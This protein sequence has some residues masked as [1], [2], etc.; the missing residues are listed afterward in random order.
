MF[1]WFRKSTQR[2]KDDIDANKTVEFFH[3]LSA[4]M[5]ELNHPKVKAFTRKIASDLALDPAFVEF[6][7][8]EKRPD[9]F[10][11]WV[12]DVGSGWTCYVPDEFD[13]AYP[14]WSTNA[15][16]TL[17]LVKGATLS[18]GKGWHDNPD[19]EMIAET[20]QGL[21]TNLIAEI[22]GVGVQDEELKR[23]AEFCGY[24]FLDEFLTRADETPD[25]SWTESLARFIA[26]VD[27]RSR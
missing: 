5:D 13:V 4:A 21:L 25:A 27:A 11:H 10:E 8:S 12:E 17:I 2:P 9:C 19:M 24:R 15:D 20:T 18:F 7:F 22:A 14:L 23:A 3:R 26:D 6:V 16:Q 1:D